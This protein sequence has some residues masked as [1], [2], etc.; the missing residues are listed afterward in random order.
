[1]A[2]GWEKGRRKEH[3]HHAERG[4]GGGQSVTT[5]TRKGTAGWK[6]GSALTR[7][8]TKR[9]LTPPRHCL[10]QPQRHSRLQHLPQQ[11]LPPPPYNLA[12]HNYGVRNWLQPMC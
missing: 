5:G 11:L 12:R 9:A 10:L 7:K 1:M 4:K 8:K 3:P 6:K 2:E